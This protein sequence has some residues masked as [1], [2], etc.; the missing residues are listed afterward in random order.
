MENFFLEDVKSI[1]KYRNTVE[2]QITADYAMFSD[3]ITRAG[4]ERCSY[5]L[6]TYEALK[7]ILH[8]VYYKPTIIWYIDAVRVMNPI[9][10]VRKGIR[11]LKYG[12][13]NDLVYHN[14]LCD[15]WYQVRAH[16]EWN[17]NRPELECD[18]VENKH[19]NIAKRMIERGGRRDTFAGTRECACEVSPCI[20]GE[21]EGA[22][23]NTGEINFGYCYCGITY[24]D[25]A[26]NEND[27]GMLT[28]RFS[29][30]VMKNGIIEFMRPEDFPENQ[31]RHIR[32]MKMK[33]FGK[34]LNNFTGLD[35]FTGGEDIELGK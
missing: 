10:H 4:G 1:K 29:D 19:H 34:E 16:F 6:P 20:F 26:L 3:V 18:R 22:F 2:F 8:S 9:R 28:V 33:K 24:P 25:E 11:P 23:D 31:K 12:G 13:G 21:G 5:D 15:V 7:G 27:K 14:Y 35:E 32:P 17:T 30:V